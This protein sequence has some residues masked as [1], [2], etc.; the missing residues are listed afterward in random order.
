MDGV[1]W[2]HRG[3]AAGGGYAALPASGLPVSCPGHLQL[4]DTSAVAT[5]LT[6][7]IRA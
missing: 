3:V 5:Q 4:E 2:V 7:T 6:A 1:P